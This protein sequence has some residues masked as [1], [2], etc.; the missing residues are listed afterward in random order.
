MC[1]V[2]PLGI[3]VGYLERNSGHCGNHHCKQGR[4]PNPSWLSSLVLSGGIAQGERVG[5]SGSVLAADSFLAVS[6][7]VISI[8][9]ILYSLKL[10][11]F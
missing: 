3:H 10:R 4:Q 7:L 9:R 11:N 2:Q 5:G 8:C 1:Q 6:I